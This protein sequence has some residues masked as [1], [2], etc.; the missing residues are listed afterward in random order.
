MGPIER[1]VSIYHRPSDSCSLGHKVYDRALEEALQELG[2]DARGV[3]ASE[4][5][6]IDS[7]LLR[8]SIR[9]LRAICTHPQIGQLQRTNDRMFKPGA[10]KSMADVLQVSLFVWFIPSLI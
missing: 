3:A 6:E 2:F 4:G 9:R 8:A 10:L 1:H 5:W 7:G